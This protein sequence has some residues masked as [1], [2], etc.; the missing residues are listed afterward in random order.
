MINNSK[1]LSIKNNCQ[2][3]SEINNGLV[4]KP[5]AYELVDRNELS[6]RDMEIIVRNIE[7][8]HELNKNEI[9]STLTSILYTF[10]ISLY[11]IK[12]KLLLDLAKGSADII[13]IIGVLG[14]YSD[15]VFHLE[16]DCQGIVVAYSRLFCSNKNRIL[17][18]TE[19]NSRKNDMSF[20]RY[21]ENLL[22]VYREKYGSSDGLLIQSLRDYL[23]S[24]DT[25]PHQYYYNIFQKVYED[26]ILFFNDR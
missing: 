10:A 25:Y 21:I 22:S 20:S 5:I 14:E 9:F 13:D 16:N 24:G 19:Y 7:I 8:Y 26:L 3:A 4:N 18:V 1:I 11:S 12:Q 15:Q 23:V 6:L 2:N 17:S